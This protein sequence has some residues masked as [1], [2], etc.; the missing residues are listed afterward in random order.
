ML[1]YAQAGMGGIPRSQALKGDN[2]KLLYTRSPRLIK[3][4]I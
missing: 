3:V 4:Q 2:S 1:A